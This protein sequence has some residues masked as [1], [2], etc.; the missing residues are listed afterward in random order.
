MNKLRALVPWV[1]RAFKSARVRGALRVAAYVSLVNAAVTLLLLRS[2]YGDAERAVDRVA[3]R[4]MRELGPLVDSPQAMTIN[5]NRMYLSTRTVDMSVKDAVDAVDRHCRERGGGFSEE[6]NALPGVN[7]QIPASARDLNKLGVAR[8]D[9]DTPNA[10]R[11]Q[12]ACIAQP[13]EAKGF[14]SFLKRVDRFVSTGDLSQLG[15]VRYFRAERLENGRTHVLSMWTEGKFDLWSMFPEQGDAPGSDSR[16]VP[17]PK[18]SVRLLTA[19]SAD[20]RQGVRIYESANPPERLLT[21]Y[22]RAMAARQWQLAPLSMSETQVISRTD[23]ARLFFKEG[24]AA[25]VVASADPGEKTAVTLLEMG[26]RGQ[27]V[28]RAEWHAGKGETRWQKDE[29]GI[30]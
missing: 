8:S 15:D 10:D 16:D 4:L 17:R 11:A 25:L 14:E 23:E 19:L 18:D 26:T 13:A 9:Q 20:G 12:I 1:V 22:E 30:R 7:R 28:G 5:G 6:V 29:K 21:E 27:A 2:A 3:S 24:A